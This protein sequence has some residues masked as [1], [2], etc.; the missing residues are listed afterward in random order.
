MPTLIY[1][2][3]KNNNKNLNRAIWISE[4]V[5]NDA[6]ELTIKLYCGKDAEL[7]LGDLR[8]SLVGGEC[9]IPYN[10][11]PQGVLRPIFTIGSVK[12]KGDPL[13]IEGKDVLPTTASA[14]AVAAL[15]SKVDELSD[16]CSELYALCRYLEERIATSRTFTI[17]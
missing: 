8:T 2:Y 14:S 9:H 4:I 3:R 16:K 17:E 15:S 7:Q 6:D 13:V 1:K 5:E 11:L 12:Y 10:R